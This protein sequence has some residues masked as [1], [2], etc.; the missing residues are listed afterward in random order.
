M[1]ARAQLDWPG[2]ERVVETFLAQHFGGTPGAMFVPPWGWTRQ[3]Q[4][5]RISRG[6]RAAR[7]Y[8]TE[9]RVPLQLDMAAALCPIAFV[10]RVMGLHPGTPAFMETVQHYDR[11]YVFPLRK[12]IAIFWGFREVDFDTL[13]ELVQ[14]KSTSDTCIAFFRRTIASPRRLPSVQTLL[15][16]FGLSREQAVRTRHILEHVNSHVHV[17]ADMELAFSQIAGLW[18]TRAAFR[19]VGLDTR[20]PVQQEEGTIGWLIEAPPEGPSLIYDVESEKWLVTS[21]GHWT[22]VLHERGIFLSD[23]WLQRIA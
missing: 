19:V 6:G 11:E 3:V 2:L 17:S 5:K 14:S 4:E 7:M 22:N 21:M 1:S 23:N 13:Q 18:R 12:R 15:D 16:R 9:L 8:W 20:T 10:E